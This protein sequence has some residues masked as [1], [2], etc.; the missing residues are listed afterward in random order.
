MRTKL[1]ERIGRREQPSGPGR[2]PGDTAGP[3]TGDSIGTRRGR[4]ARA[5]VGLVVGVLTTVHAQLLT[6]VDYTAGVGERPLFDIDGFV[7]PDGN[8]VRIGTFTP[9]FD[10]LA[11][12]AWLG[13]LQAHWLPY[14]ATEVKTL[15][16]LYPGSF[17]DTATSADARFNRQ[18]IYLWAFKTSDA[19]PPSGGTDGFGNVEQYGLFSSRSPAWVFPV[20]GTGP[21]D[22]LGLINTLQVDEAYAGSIVGGSLRLVPEVGA[23]GAM[24]ALGLAGW[25]LAR[26]TRS[27]RRRNGV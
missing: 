5:L 19:G 4:W 22:N 10:V 14:G 1:F 20:L 3:A 15:F 8:Q 17:A 2:G 25:A 23:A 9:G 11:N 13:R 21:P 7:I 27:A 24:T 26:R 6:Q 16:G 18:R 12:A